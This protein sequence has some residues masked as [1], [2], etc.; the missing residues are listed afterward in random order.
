[1]FRDHFRD[2]LQPY[3]GY[4]RS[5]FDRKRLNAALAWLSTQSVEHMLIAFYNG[6]NNLIDVEQLAKGGRHSVSFEPDDVF[7]RCVVLSA[8]GFIAIHNHPDGGAL[9]SRQDIAWTQRM[10]CRGAM[11]EIH[12]L[13]SLIV[14]DQGACNSLRQS[15]AIDP[16]YPAR[17]WA[18]HGP[19]IARAMLEL[20]RNLANQAEEIRQYVEGPGIKLLLALYLENS[21][22]LLQEISLITGLARSTVAR[23]L[24]GLVVSGLATSISPAAKPRFQRYRLTDQGFA[25]TESLL[26]GDEAFRPRPV[27]S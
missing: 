11:L 27:L 10:I 4:E 5:E 25:V 2:H 3:A 14:D 18:H 20:E 8:K 23:A 24:K 1:M 9:P 15:K 21:G 7:R 22:K 17:P 16:W 13:D 26:R 19:A 12:M 6:R